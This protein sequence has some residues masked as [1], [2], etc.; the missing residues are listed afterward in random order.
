MADT[1]AQQTG[2]ANW[3]GNQSAPTAH[4][5]QP[6]SEDELRDIVTRG[7]GPVRMVGAGHSFTPIVSSQ[8]TIINLDH[9]N[10]V[11]WADAETLQARVRAGSRLKDLSPALDEAGLAFRNLGD[12]NVQSFAGAA[13]TATHGTGENLGCLSSEIVALRLMTAEGNILEASIDSNFDLLQAVQVSVGALGILLE[14]TVNVCPAYNLHRRTWVEPIEDI[15]SAIEERWRANRNYEIFY[16]PF[17]GYGVNIQHNQTDDAETERP[18]S[19]DEAALAGLRA[20]RNKMKW[21]NF[22]RR[23]M[24]AAGLKRAAAENVIGPSWQLLASPRETRFNEMEYHLPVDTGLDALKDVIAYI[25]TH[26]PDVFFPV[27]VRK[28][29]GDT[30]WLSPFQGGPRISIAVHAAAEED[31]S[32]FFDG[33]EPIFRAAGGRPHWGKL[34]SLGAQ[35]L[36]SLYPEFSKFTALRKQLDPAGRFMTPALAKLWGEA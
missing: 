22:L 11:V 12:I 26:R 15:L 13:A 34:H 35:E 17:S 25:E 33:V 20:I 14:A 6:R 1:Y 10:G 4:F 7:E 18:P 27:E 9:M 29:A 8:G 3:S 24:L 32:W 21:S 16:I 23:K 30:A 5:V 31:H 19:D 28:T 36:D 2:W